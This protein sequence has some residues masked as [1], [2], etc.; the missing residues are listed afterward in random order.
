MAL[1]DGCTR[2]F[3][4]SQIINYEE[5]NHKLVL[6]LFLSPLDNHAGEKKR[7]VGRF[8]H[9]GALLGKRLLSVE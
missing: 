4:F 5:N 3:L 8:F 7:Y 1:F 9:D 6:L 2:M